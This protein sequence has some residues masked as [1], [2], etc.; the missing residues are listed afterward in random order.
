M[1]LNK[2]VATNPTLISYVE[3]PLSVALSNKQSLE[4]IQLL[5]HYDAD[6]NYQF[7]FF[8]SNYVEWK[9]R[10]NRI[11]SPLFLA[12]MNEA[13]PLAVIKL[14]L[15]KG[16]NRYV[17]IDGKSLFQAILFGFASEKKY[18]PILYE[19][20]SK[21]PELSVRD[22][23]IIEMLL[24]S[25]IDVNTT[26]HETL[27]FNDAPIIDVAMQYGFYDVVE[28]LAN[29]GADMNARDFLDQTPLFIA[30][31]NL[32]NPDLVKILLKNGANVFDYINDK[33]LL[34]TLKDKDKSEKSSSYRERYKKIIYLFSEYGA[35]IE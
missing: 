23:A 26:I 12:I 25:G 1:L 31:I 21:R 33:P 30:A 9:E 8:G 7:N 18:A 11:I 5:I 19:N 28:L 22:R 3:T 27:I 34:E 32:V 14:L 35:K 16:A 24:D 17:M 20:G 4:V 15:K 2:R 6:V 13:M 10:K 29:K